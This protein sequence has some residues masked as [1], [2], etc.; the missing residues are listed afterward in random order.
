MTRR[1][2]RRFSD[3]RPE[4]TRAVS[5]PEAEEEYLRGVSDLRKAGARM[6]PEI[7]AQL[8]QEVID[9]LR[10]AGQEGLSLRY[11]AALQWRFSIASMT[12]EVL[13]WVV[14]TSAAPT[15]AC[16]KVTAGIKP[17]RSEGIGAGGGNRAR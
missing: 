5:A 8:T 10:A 12:K 2:S 13:T 17:E 4:A 7:D 11:M 9:T 3:L 14:S 1:S 15:A 16:L 6:D